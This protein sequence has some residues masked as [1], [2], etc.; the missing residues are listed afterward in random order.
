M[1]HIPH[2]RTN[3]PP[4]PSNGQLLPIGAIPTENS[5]SHNNLPK[6]VLHIPNDTDLD[7]SLLESSEPSDSSYSK[8]VRRMRNELRVK[9]VKNMIKSALSLYIN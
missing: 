3:D 1:V 9:G 2:C 4:S 7:S 8:R 6:Q 5:S